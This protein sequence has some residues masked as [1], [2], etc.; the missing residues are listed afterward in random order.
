MIQPLR[1]AHFW[2]WAMVPLLLAI[3]FAA[4]LI[5]RRPT[6]PTNENAHWEKYK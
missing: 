1:R 5:V 3:L 6:I 2:I 4:G